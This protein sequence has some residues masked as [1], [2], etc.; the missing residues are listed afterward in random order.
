LPAD[1]E[2][3]LRSMPAAK[4]ILNPADAAQE[5]RGGPRRRA[6]RRAG[7]VPPRSPTTPVEED[8]RR[9]A[10]GRGAPRSRARCQATPQCPRP[11]CRDAPGQATGPRDARPSDRPEAA[12][13]APPSVGRH[14]ARDQ[15][16][17]SRGAMLCT[18]RAARRVV[19]RGPRRR[20][21]QFAPRPHHHPPC[22][23]TNRARAPCDSPERTRLRMC[24][25]R[26]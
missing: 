9:T 11:S 22:L 20:C 16:H 26:S 5:L 4:A 19:W 17:C 3:R 18:I 1:L 13:W 15:P 2:P 12:G 8:R 14:S 10:D 6:T 24:A 21:W 23:T 25:A 7:P